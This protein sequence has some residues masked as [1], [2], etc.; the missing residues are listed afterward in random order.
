MERYALSSD[1]FIRSRATSTAQLIGIP[2]QTA[3]IT[4]KRPV[5]APVTIVA[6]PIAPSDL[7]KEA[8]EMKEREERLRVEEGQRKDEMLRTVPESAS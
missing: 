5:Q 8:Q 4:P 2:I 7:D 6:T 3:I 1:E